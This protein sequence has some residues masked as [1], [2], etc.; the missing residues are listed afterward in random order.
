MI[1]LFYSDIIF[2]NISSGI[3]LTL[4]QLVSEIRL[5]VIRTGLSVSQNILQVN[6]KCFEYEN[7]DIYLSLNQ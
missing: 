1:F 2:S 3:Y 5:A 4:K 7:S 6:L